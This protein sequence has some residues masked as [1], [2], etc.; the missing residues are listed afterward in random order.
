MPGR[1][2]QAEDVINKLRQ[3]DVELGRGKSVPSVCKLIG[4]TEAAYYRWRR[5]Y[6]GMRA[7]RRF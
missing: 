6:C 5:A 4:V 3:A 7:A 2:H 1:R